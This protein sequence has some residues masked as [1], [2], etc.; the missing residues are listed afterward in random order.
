MS[1]ALNSFRVGVMIAVN[2]SYFIGSITAIIL[3]LIIPVDLI[4]DAELEIEEQWNV[5]EEEPLS[6][7]KE[8]DPTLTEKD[9]VE[10]QFKDDSEETVV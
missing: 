4:D 2:T 8:E 6:T 10:E 9:K 3:N 1:E 7:S 5:E